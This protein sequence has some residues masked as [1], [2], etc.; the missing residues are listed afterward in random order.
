MIMKN[1]DNYKNKKIIRNYS[2]NDNNRY[3]LYIG[4]CIISIIVLICYY[5][6]SNNKNTYNNIKEDKSKEIVYTK[7]SIESDDYPIRVPYINIKSSDIE[8]IN[9]N[10][11][12]Y[13]EWY[14]ANGDSSIIIYR[15]EINN[16]IL[17]LLIRVAT[18]DKIPL[19]DFKS[20]IIDLKSLKEISDEEIL[21]KFNLDSNQVLSYF[22]N[23]FHKYYDDLISSGIYNKNRCNYNCFLNNIDLSNYLEGI[24]YYVSNNSLIAYRPFRIYNNNHEERY[25]KDFDFQYILVN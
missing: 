23:I 20:Y 6:I 22:D 7:Y 25:F 16:D 24:S 10:I 17:S 9:S 4:I 11:D 21:N 2:N 15:Y 19:Y 18:F 3:L 13:L 1:P 14:L 5:L 8:R 12:E